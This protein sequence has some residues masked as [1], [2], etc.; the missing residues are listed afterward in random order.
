MGMP[1]CGGSYR[2]IRQAAKELGFPIG[3]EGKHQFIYFRRDAL[4]SFS[5]PQSK[6][7]RW[8]RTGLPPPSMVGQKKY[9]ALWHQKNREMI[10]KKQ[11]EAYRKK[12]GG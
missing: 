9:H 11:R 7:R 3:R 6:M 1:L 12:M 2:A 10:L 4:P 5:S 8:N